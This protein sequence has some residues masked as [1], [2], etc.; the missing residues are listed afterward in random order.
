MPQPDF[1]R[2]TLSQSEKADYAPPPI[3]LLAPA[4]FQTLLQILAKRREKLLGVTPIPKFIGS[5]TLA[6]HTQTY[7]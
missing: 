4:D 7:V 2:S 3:L 5:T 1:G 6:Y